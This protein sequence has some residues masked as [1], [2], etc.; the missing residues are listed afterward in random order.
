[1]ISV[2]ESDIINYIPFRYLL[3]GNNK[4]LLNFLKLARKAYSRNTLH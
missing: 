2:Y 3:T 1:M 4:I